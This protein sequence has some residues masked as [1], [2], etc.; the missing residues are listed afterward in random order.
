LEKVRTDPE[1]ISAIKDFPLPKS[2]KAF[3]ALKDM[4]CSAPVL[5]SPDF[6]RPFFVQCD[7][8]KSGVGGVLVQKTDEGDEFPI[9][10]VSKKLNK[11]QRNYSV[12]E[13]ECLAAIVCIKRFRAYIE[14]HEFTVI[15]DHASLKW[16]MSQTDLHSRL[17]RWSLK[18]QG[19]NFKIENR[20]GR[21]NVVPDALSRVNE[22]ELAAID[23]S[24]GLMVDLQS[25]AFKSGEYIELQEKISANSEKCPDL[26]IADGLLYRRT[27]H[28]TGDLL[29][30]GC[31]TR[32]WGK[33]K[34]IR[35]TGR[36]VSCFLLRAVFISAVKGFAAI[37]KRH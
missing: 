27:D 2:L 9:A 21:L 37:G 8:S 32:N 33:R 34:R 19:F 13:Q 14:G 29:W 22:E 10:F 6:S 7:A 28:A 35:S 25:S 16:L 36:N 11:A 23:A 24:H 18:L 15:T 5:R 20:S 30:V 3:R 26:R 31:R 4:L 17:A 12:T 1:K